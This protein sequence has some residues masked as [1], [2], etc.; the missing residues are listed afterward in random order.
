M[1]PAL[2]NAFDI[3][4]QRGR[5]VAAAAGRHPVRS[6]LVLPALLLLYV[7]VLLPFTP[8]IGDLRRAKAEQP[9]V[10]LA[11][12]GTAL[13]EYQRVNRQWVPLDKVAPNV[14]HALIATEDHR[15]YEHH[16]IDF[17]RTAGAAFNTLR[18]DL[19][20]GSTITQQLAR[21]TCSRRKSAVPP[22]SRASSRKP[23]P[24]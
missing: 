20:G 10:L 7:L 17:R 8:S 22:A 24:R 15:F 2:R 18:G 23:S 4:A 19:Q 14:V 11:Q 21:A 3:A 16:G 9:S 5:Q 6:A 13:A 1:H 12:D